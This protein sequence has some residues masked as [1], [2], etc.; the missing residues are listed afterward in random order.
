MDGTK[1]NLEDN[2][3]SGTIPS[4]IWKLSLLKNL[5]VD[6]NKLTGTLPSKIGEMM[7][8]ERLVAS[9]NSLT[10][11]LPSIPSSSNLNVIS[12]EFNQF[13]GSIPAS[14]FD[15]DLD[16]L[17]LRQ[18]D[19]VGDVPNEFCEKIPDG[20]SVDDREWLLHEPKVNCSCCNKAACH[21]W[22]TTDEN[23]LFRPCP[24]G[25]LH[26]L[27]FVSVANISDLIT[28]EKRYYDFN[29]FNGF[30]ELNLC[31]SQTGCYSFEYGA[32]GEVEGLV[33]NKAEFF[34]YSDSEKKLKRQDLLLEGGCPS[35]MI[36]GVSIHKNHPKRIGLNQ[37]TQL[38]LHDMTLLDD[39]SSPG[40]KALCWAMTQDRLYDNYRYCDGTLLQRFVLIYFYYTEGFL[41]DFE[42]L[43]LLDTCDWPG[44]SCDSYQQF[45]TSIDLSNQNLTGTLTTEIGLLTTLENINLS[46]NDLKGNI[47]E[48]LHRNLHQIKFFN[49]GNNSFGG[50]FPYEILSHPH[51]VE[52]NISGNNFVG[53][54]PSFTYSRDLGKKFNTL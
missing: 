21:I 25:N 10:G 50:A 8:L 17:W 49:I 37:F 5:I 46:N 2:F 1:V 35:V 6:V 22:N 23:E 38:V 45:V 18:N 19:L 44:I 28:N 48:S 54:L 7:S 9:A 4:D 20:L 39:P 11:R 43:S 40:Y 33:E 16:F 13:T 47:D 24:N 3:F 52:L 36:C 26:K 53:R 27:G 32:I 12:L 34:E 30:K 29:G 42:E 41:A 14:Y 15:L 31:L 51:L